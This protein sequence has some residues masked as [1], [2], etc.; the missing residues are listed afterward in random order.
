[1]S[2]RIRGITIELNGDA[3]QLEDALKSVNKRS[4]DLA[5]EL[6]DID[7]LLKFNPGNTELL[8]QRQQLLTDRI[9]ATSEKL[10]GLRAAQAQ[11][12][13]QFDRGDIGIE[14]YNRFRREIITTEGSLN[15]LRNQL[16]RMTDEQQRV[17]DST[18]QLGTLF[19]ATGTDIDQFA[20]ALG[21]NLTNAIRNGTAS[22]QQLEQAIDQIG[23]AALG[24]DTDLGRMREALRNVDNGASLD[25]VRQDLS[26]VANEA[27]E[28]ETSVRNFGGELSQT[29][30]GL[31]AGGGI[32]GVVSAALDTSSLDTKIEIMFDV[33]E[34]SKASVKAAIK[35][36]GTYGIEAEEALEGVRRQWALN[37]DASDE[38]N[39]AIVKGAS[40]IA[41]AYTAIDFTE[42]IQEANEIG[43]ALGISN[44]EAMGMVN[45]LLKTGFPPEQLDIIAE[46]GEQLAIA[47]YNAEEVQNILAASVDTKSWNID[48]LLDGLKEAKIGLSEFGLVIP[49]AL[50]EL[51]AK[52]TISST[53]M[54]AWGAAVAEGGEAGSA[55][56]VA[57]A[58]A[59]AGIEDATLRNEIGVQVFGTK[60]EDQGMKLVDTLMVAEQGTANLGEGI[61]TLN[62]DIATMDA[63]PAVKLQEALT[64][65]MAALQPILTK[66]A[67]LVTA[68]ATWAAENPVVTATIAAISVG[69]GILMGIFAALA[70]VVQLIIANFALIKTVFAAITGPIGIAVAAITALIAIGVALYKNW[71][72]VSKKGSEIWASIQKKLSEI[73]ASIQK[74]CE[75]V[76]ENIKKSISKEW[77]DVKKTASNTWNAIKSAITTVWNAIKSTATSVFNS[78]KDTITTIFN[79]V[80]ST[81]TTVWNTIKSTVQTAVTSVWNSVKTAFN[82]LLSTVTTMMN[83]VSTS[84]SNIWRNVM[85]FFNNIDLFSVGT[86]IIRGL[87]SG[88]NSMAGEVWRKVSDIASSVKDAFTN[89]LKIKSPSR[90]FE[91]YGVNINE[92]LMEGLEGSARK[93]QGTMKSIY[94][95]FS[96]N[97]EKMLTA[98][99]SSNT[100]NV[101]NSRSYQPSITII[102][103]ANSTSPS[104]IA[105]KALQ[106]QRQLAMEWGV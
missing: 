95:S 88:I 87:L 41:S 81:I 18:R 3:T 22:S 89:M 77:D 85:S 105:R 104:E 49:K 102:N 57:V 45:T 40:L 83:N 21:S 91:G 100:S 5:R 68:F 38:T 48:N 69:L 93:L 34:E 78:I 59:L 63:D 80:K 92:G 32:A 94:G 106:T 103:Q 28:A 8:A 67:E 74:K 58:Q 27:E 44:E 24:A 39:T 1:M 98:S 54:Q 75:E 73:W 96:D 62:D 11:V 4:N 43:A 47:G 99:S 56:M 37:K 97:S 64:N 101:N 82:G 15:G 46:Y 35:E 66:V 86:D 31:V 26:Q 53:Q 9:A 79:N 61:K 25:Q 17:A 52:T 70:P 30:G 33:P 84:I 36:V 13:A 23:L 16:Q 55:A 19:Q 2:S 29:I 6:K 12:Q 51:L 20:D 76:F 7:K 65:M 10:E 71:D 60:F 14:Q 42:L 90:V 50:D 72:E